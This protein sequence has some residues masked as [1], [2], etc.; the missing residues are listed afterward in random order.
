MSGKK[1]IFYFYLLLFVCNFILFE[2]N[3]SYKDGDKINYVNLVLFY[4]GQ[5]PTQ[6]M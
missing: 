6:K 3:K 2:Y 4:V 5:R 1:N